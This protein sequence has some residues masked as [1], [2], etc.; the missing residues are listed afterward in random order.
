MKWWERMREPEQTSPGGSVS[1]ATAV[2]GG[3]AEGFLSPSNG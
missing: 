1:V 3:N 2:Q